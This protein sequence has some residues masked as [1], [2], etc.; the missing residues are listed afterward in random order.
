[1]TLGEALPEVVVED[2]FLARKPLLPKFPTLLLSNGYSEKGRVELYSFG[3]LR[4]VGL[5][6]DWRHAE[7]KHGIQY[8]TNSTE[9]RRMF[10]DFGDIKTF[11]DL[12]ST[13]GMVFVTFVSE[14]GNECMYMRFTLVSSMTFGQQSERENVYKGLKS[15]DD[16]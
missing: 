10:E 16:R 7:A 2:A 13:R 15:A 14:I 1:M 4:R 5:S 12:I 9:V 11:F 6:I 3:T 8:E